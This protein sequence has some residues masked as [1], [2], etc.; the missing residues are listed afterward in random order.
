MK[1]TMYKNGKQRGQSKLSE[2][3]GGDAPP[4]KRK[5]GSNTSAMTAD[6]LPTNN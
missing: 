5:L 1:V 6:L 4:V 3:E 2:G